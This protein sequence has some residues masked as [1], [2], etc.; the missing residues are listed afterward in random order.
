MKIDD[1]MK[2]Y[3]LDR[4]EPRH[5]QEMAQR[6][7]DLIRS[8]KKMTQSSRQRLIRELGK[9]VITAGDLTH[10]NKAIKQYNE[11]IAEAKKKLA[12]TKDPEIVEL[13]KKRIRENETALQRLKS[14]RKQFGKADY[15]VIVR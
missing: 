13:I 14:A 2:R 4:T 15:K 1:F 5:P 7:R 12:E 6:A 3:C 9:N 8:D 10:P 11:W